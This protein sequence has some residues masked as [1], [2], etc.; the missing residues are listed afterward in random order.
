MM[1]WLQQGRIKFLDLKSFKWLLE[2]GGG[3][4]NTFWFKQSRATQLPR[5]LLRFSR[6]VVFKGAQKGCAV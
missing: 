2:E 4:G 1:N 3:S 5:W 6:V